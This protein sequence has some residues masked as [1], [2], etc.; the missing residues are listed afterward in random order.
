MLDVMKNPPQVPVVVQWTA[1]RVR[2]PDADRT[3]LMYH[4]ELGNDPIGAGWWDG[5]E[6]R[7]AESAFPLGSDCVTW[8]ADYPEPP[9]E[10]EP[11][12]HLLGGAVAGQDM[13][14]S[15]LAMARTE[16]HHNEECVPGQSCHCENGALMRRID[17]VLKTHNVRANLTKGAADEA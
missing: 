1:C 12:D 13:L 11:H 10:P 16:I 2:M 4:P 5:E 7:A 3:V 15:L 6:W 17:E 14:R 8:W 9:S